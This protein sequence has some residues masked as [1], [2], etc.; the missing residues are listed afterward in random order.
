MARPKKSADTPKTRDK[1]IEAARIEFASNG[2]AAPLEAIAQRCNIRRP[3]LLHHFNSK[4]ALVAA[5]VEDIIRKARERLQVVVGTKHD[6]YAEK[7]QAIFKVLRDLEDEEKG[8]G[9]VLL[10]AMLADDED[11]SVSR[12]VGEFINVIH[13]TAL[14][15]GA[16]DSH[17]SDDIRAATAQL[18][19]GEFARLA[20]ASKAEH[21]WGKADGIDPL[22][23]AYFLT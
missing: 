11:E 12:R 1:I 8:V 5:V 10:H 21:V 15:A 3:S 18:V 23:K 16:A 13:A 19:I 17:D 9:S 20:L 4:Q 6:D 2:I 22:Y 7:M 14:L